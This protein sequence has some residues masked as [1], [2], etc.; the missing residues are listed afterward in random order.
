MQQYL[1]RKLRLNTTDLIRGG[2]D[3]KI[4]SLGRFN[5]ENKQSSSSIIDPTTVHKIDLF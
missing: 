1:G 3:K 2:R 4:Q 5:D